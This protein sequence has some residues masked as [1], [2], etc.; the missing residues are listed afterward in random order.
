MVVCVYVWVCG[1]G[2]WVLWR[3][4]GGWGGGGGVSVSG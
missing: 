2:N 1:C 3:S 4:L